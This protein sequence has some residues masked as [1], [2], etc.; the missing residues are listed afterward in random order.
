M[1]LSSP[2]TPATLLAPTPAL[3]ADRLVAAVTEVAERV[4]AR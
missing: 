3:A 4:L 2:E 1:V